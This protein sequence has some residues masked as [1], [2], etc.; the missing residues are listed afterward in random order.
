MALTK[1]EC[2]YS[3]FHVNLVLKSLLKLLIETI[4]FQKLSSVSGISIT[5]NIF[6]KYTLR[7]YKYA[8]C[9]LSE[10]VS[11]QISRQSAESE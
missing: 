3:N 9:V 10:K 6:N 8:E 5:H 2:Q 1:D 11:N 4:A 7:F